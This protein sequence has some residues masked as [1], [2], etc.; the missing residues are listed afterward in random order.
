MVNTTYCDVCNHEY[1]CNKKHLQSN[2]HT[3]NLFRQISPLDQETKHCDR[4]DNDILNFF[5]IINT[6]NHANTRTMKKGKVPLNSPLKTQFGEFKG[7]IKIRLFRF[8]D[9]GPSSIIEAVDMVEQSIETIIKHTLSEMKTFKFYV[10]V[11]LNMVREGDETTP[12]MRTHPHFISSFQDFVRCDVYDELQR[13]EQD[14]DNTVVG[15]G[16]AITKILVS[17]ISILSIISSYISLV[18]ISNIKLSVSI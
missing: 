3:I 10:G 11:K 8:Q 15:S 5:L 6:F 18:L 7:L 9:P 2:K 1:K 16:F 12:Y 17:Y 14:V 4:C 13:Q